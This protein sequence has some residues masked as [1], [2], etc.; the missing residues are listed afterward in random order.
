MRMKINKITQK[1]KH[2]GPYF[3]HFSQFSYS[4]SVNLKAILTIQQ[5]IINRI[6][7]KP[8]IKYITIT[9]K[10]TSLFH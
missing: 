10:V 4:R 6:I 1:L 8:N 5:I 9:I 2:G 3:L 7:I